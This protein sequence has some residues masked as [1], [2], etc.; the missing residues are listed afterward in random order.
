MLGLR[1]LRLEENLEFDT[2]TMIDLLNE[3]SLLLPF[4]FI[5]GYTIP[6]LRRDSAEMRV[7]MVVG[8]SKTRLL[9]EKLELELEV[10]GR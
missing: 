10:S 1:H 7:L 8:F 3:D 9:P 4:F 6:C 2:S 5:R